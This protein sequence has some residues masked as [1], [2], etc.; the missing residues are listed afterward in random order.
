MAHEAGHFL[1]ALTAK[2]KYDS[3]YGHPEKSQDMLMHADHL[4]K[5]IP[6]S[7]ATKFNYGYHS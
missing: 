5:K 1:G 7:A 6:Y 3:E 2:G 4:G